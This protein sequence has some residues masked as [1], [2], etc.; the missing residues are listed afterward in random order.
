MEGSWFARVK[1]V[2]DGEEQVLPVS[3]IKTLQKERFHPQSLNDFQIDR[4]V[5][6]KTAKYDPGQK[7]K[8]F[9]CYV[10]QLASKYSI[11][12]M[13][14]VLP[15]GQI[16]STVC[17]DHSAT[18]NTS[19]SLFPVGTAHELE[20]LGQKRIRWRTVPLEEINA[21]DPSGTSQ[22]EGAGRSRVTPVTAQR[23]ARKQ[24]NS[25]RQQSKD[26]AYN[27]FLQR[28]NSTLMNTVAGDDRVV[29]SPSPAAVSGT[30]G[31]DEEPILINRA[32][33]RD[34][35][36]NVMRERE[37]VLLATMGRMVATTIREEL[38][39]LPAVLKELPAPNLR[40]AAAHSVEQKIPLGHDVWCTEPEFNSL[41]LSRTDSD[42]ATSL[43]LGV[44]GPEK[45]PLMRV[46]PRKKD[47]LEQF[48]S[49][50]LAVAKD[51]FRKRL[52]AGNPD[53]NVEEEVSALPAFL[54][55]RAQDLAGPRN[56][57]ARPK[58][59]TS[60]EA[61]NQTSRP[62]PQKR[63]SSSGSITSLLKAR[64]KKLKGKKH[65]M[66]E[67]NISTANRDEEPGAGHDLETTDMQMEVP[68]GPSG[69][70]ARRVDDKPS[71][72]E[73]EGEYSDAELHDLQ[74]IPI[75]EA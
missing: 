53:Q 12:S 43:L 51:L 34:L 8:Y 69:L 56:K 5:K 67:A 27:K 32:D 73:E 60:D 24:Q 6:A 54:A 40:A 70:N 29:R 47:H 13:L 20:G 22:D 21:D 9:R 35:V 42:W 61:E 11:T 65:D 74:I 31:R 30:S 41:A 72:D 36:Q 25:A 37:E 15:R 38:A 57:A 28:C 58:K 2:R 7:E 63:G 17:V 1:F 39:K 64:S 10:G 49:T 71:A 23:E 45:A 66:G 46:Y 4:V 59:G 52:Q 50:F 14:G 33:L 16:P 44:F 55:R 62:V 19:F 68:P 48:P 26:A 3:K 75:N 18:H